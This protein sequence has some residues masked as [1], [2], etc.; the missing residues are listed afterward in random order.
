MFICITV[1]SESC[2]YCKINFLELIEG[3]RSRS[4][5]YDLPLRIAF[6]T[7][8]R[9]AVEWE[10]VYFLVTVF[11]LFWPES[12][13][14]CRLQYNQF[15]SLNKLQKR[16]FPVRENIQSTLVIYFCLAKAVNFVVNLLYLR[17]SPPKTDHFIFW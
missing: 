11:F 8:Q 14:S 7:K 2:T 5:V 10:V 9:H 12:K 1:G 17:V 16:D 13:P 6:F 4:S 15:A 3:H